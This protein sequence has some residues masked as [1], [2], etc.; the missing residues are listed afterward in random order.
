M[1]DRR[2]AVLDLTVW[3]GGGGGAPAERQVV[4]RGHLTRAENT[5]IILVLDL[6]ILNILLIAHVLQLNRFEIYAIV[7]SEFNTK[8]TIL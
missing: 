1:R 3:R 2:G 5:A 6:N 7:L 8:C 4:L